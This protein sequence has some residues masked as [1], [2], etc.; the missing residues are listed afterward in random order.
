MIAII[1]PFVNQI[2][3]QSPNFVVSDP[4]SACV[5][6]FHGARFY[7]A[8]LGGQHN[9]PHFGFAAGGSPSLINAHSANSDSVA[10]GSFNAARPSSAQ[11]CIKKRGHRNARVS[12]QSI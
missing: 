7:L 3:G 6:L 4:Q 5:I 10:A 2:G 1:G 12:V 8:H 11:L 9:L